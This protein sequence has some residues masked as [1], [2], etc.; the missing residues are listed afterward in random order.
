MDRIQLE[1]T[2][3]VTRDRTRLTPKYGH[4]PEPHD[5]QVASWAAMG[6]ALVVLAVTR[7]PVTR[8]ADRR[9]YF[10]I[11]CTVG[12]VLVAVYVTGIGAMHHVV[13]SA[14]TASG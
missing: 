9:G 7:A 14:A 3:R 13:Q 11:F 12:G 2:T 10:Y 8:T 4:P 1:L 6:V 5:R